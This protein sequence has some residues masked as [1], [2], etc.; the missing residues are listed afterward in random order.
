[1]P[2]VFGVAPHHYRALSP[3]NKWVGIH[4]GLRGFG[5]YTVRSSLVGC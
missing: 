5:I 2:A 4:P 3:P 1:M